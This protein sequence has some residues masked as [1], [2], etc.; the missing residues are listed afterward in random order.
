MRIAAALTLFIWIAPAA[1]GQSREDNG[2]LSPALVQPPT[3]QIIVKWRDGPASTAA[4]AGARMQKLGAASGMRLQRKQQ[5]T[6]ETDVLQLDRALG[7][8]EMNALLARLSV[9]PN[10]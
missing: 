6:A 8:A 1:F 4:A 10:V 7:G 2:H 3:N 5:I 9:D